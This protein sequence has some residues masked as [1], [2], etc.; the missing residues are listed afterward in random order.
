MV[1]VGAGVDGFG[2]GMA[3]GALVIRGHAGHLPGDGFIAKAVEAT[4]RCAHSPSVGCTC[5]KGF[6]EGFEGGATIR[7]E[8]RQEDAFR[9]GWHLFREVFVAE[10]EAMELTS[11]VDVFRLDGT[12]EVSAEVVVGIEGEHEVADCCDGEGCGK[13]TGIVE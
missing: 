7:I 3:E 8:L 11:E 10:F 4:E 2:V 9:L 12:F 1:C 5:I 13:G 6:P